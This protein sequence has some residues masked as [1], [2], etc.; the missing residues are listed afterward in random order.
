ME[1]I[2]GEARQ[3]GRQI[4]YSRCKSK[5]DI[6]VCEEKLACKLNSALNEP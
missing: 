5:R 6:R 4:E 1:A 3:A 2:T